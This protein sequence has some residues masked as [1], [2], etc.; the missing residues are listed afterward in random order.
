MSKQKTEVIEK[1]SGSIITREQM[2]RY[3]ETTNAI[4]ELIVGADKSARSLAKLLYTVKTEKLYLVGG[5]ENVSE[6]AREVHDFAKS[7]TSEAINIYARFADKETG[8]ILPQY[9]TYA[10]RALKMLKGFTD[11]EIA[12]MG[13]TPE[14]PSTKLEALIKEYKQSLIEAPEEEAEAVEEAETVEEAEAVEESE[15]VEEAEAPHTFPTRT[16][17]LSE[18]S[19]TDELYDII[20]QLLEDVAHSKYDIVITA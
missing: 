16:I 17:K 14:M 15:A 8:E 11:D 19:G 20:S 10:W 18:V 7:T 4:R 1:V 9:T 3:E 13:A 12:E 2:K 5:F 6:Y